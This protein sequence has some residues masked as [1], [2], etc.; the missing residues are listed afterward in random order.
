MPTH[1]HA[2]RLIMVYSLLATV[3]SSF[4]FSGVSALQNGIG[5][6]SAQPCL[7]NR[8]INATNLIV[9]AK[10]L[11]VDPNS[12]SQLYLKLNETVASLNGSNTTIHPGIGC[13]TADNYPSQSGI[14]N[15]IV[16]TTERLIA[17]KD[18]EGDNSGFALQVSPLLGLVLVPVSGVVTALT[19]ETVRRMKFRTSRSRDFGSTERSRSKSGHGQLVTVL[20]CSMMIYS[21]VFFIAMNPRHEDHFY[22]LSVLDTNHTTSAYYPTTDGIV[23]V[24]EKVS[25]SVEAEGH[26]IPTSV[27]KLTVGIAGSPASLTTNFPEPD[28]KTL[29]E[30]YY[31]AQNEGTWSLPLNWSIIS[32]SRNDSKVDMCMGLNGIATNATYTS[33]SGNQRLVIGLWAFDPNQQAYRLESWLQMWFDVSGYSPTGL[34]ASRCG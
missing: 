19:F 21:L 4:T 12:L 9:K 11:G 10:T 30:Y 25:W 23:N 17:D 32:A 2:L 20:I 8:I 27:L 22:T 34:Q 5:Q 3:I 28:T 18:Q 24:G 14:I 31:V 15:S 7:E 6:N 26:K 13:V 16:K 33:K 29:A 1:K